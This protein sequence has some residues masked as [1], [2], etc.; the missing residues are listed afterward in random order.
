M[1]RRDH[2]TRGRR[3][4]EATTR[5]PSCSSRAEPQVPKPGEGRQTDGRD[6]LAAR[7]PACPSPR[8]A[9]QATTATARPPASVEAIAALYGL[10]LERDLT[11]L[12][13][14]DVD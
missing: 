13:E 5:P 12:S 10:E 7:I 3:N 8:P 1:D 6:S 4:G 9:P 14:I 11:A 2:R